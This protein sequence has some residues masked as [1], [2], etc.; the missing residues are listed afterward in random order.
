MTQKAP[1]RECGKVL[2]IRHENKISNI[3]CPETVDMFLSFHFLERR[4]RWESL[5]IDAN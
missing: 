5:W 1:G 2:F 3:V 4:E